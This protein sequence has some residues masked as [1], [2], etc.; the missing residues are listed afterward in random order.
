MVNILTVDFEDWYQ[1]GISQKYINQGSAGFIK[2]RIHE[3]SSILLDLL[4]ERSVK[5]TFFVVGSIA[6]KYPKLIAKIDKAGHRIGAH[7]FDHKLVY[8][9]SK[10]EFENE[11]VMT[12]R[13]LRNIVSRPVE[14]FR[15]PNWSINTRSPWAIDLL[16]KHGFKY[17]SSMRYFNPPVK[18]PISSNPIVEFP[19]SH[20][21]S[22][23]CNIPYGG[24]SFL[25]LY[26]LLAT[27]FFIDWANKP[28]IM[29]L[30]P[31]ELDRQIPRLK[32]SCFDMLIQYGGI[33]SAIKKVK[34]IL[35]TR[36]FC[37]ME[38]YLDKSDPKKKWLNKM[39]YFV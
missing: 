22:T 26:P 14:S 16:R 21:G 19:R 38:D 13:V 11:L 12:V 31:W 30:H 1:T 32:G 20:F 8:R 17:D 2:E 27:D 39:Y 29:Y 9:Q 15:A 37:P 6:E 34:Y 7:G 5:A 35:K 18:Q 25:R 28:Y 4:A 10:D 36:Q 33:N 3:T 24:G 23:R